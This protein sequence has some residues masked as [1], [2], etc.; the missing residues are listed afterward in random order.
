MTTNPIKH[1]KIASI[2]FSLLAI[3]ITNINAASAQTCTSNCLSVYSIELT[4]LGNSI[5]VDRQ[6]DR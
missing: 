2:L 6:T 3:F 5:R 1:W 4:D